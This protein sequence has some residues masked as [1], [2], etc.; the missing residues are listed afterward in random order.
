MKKWRIEKMEI[1]LAYFDISQKQEEEVRDH[2][3]PTT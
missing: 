3:V 2:I 1:F